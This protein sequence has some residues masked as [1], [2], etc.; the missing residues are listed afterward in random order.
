MARASLPRRQSPRS[1]KPGRRRDDVFRAKGGPALAMLQITDVPRGLRALDA[2]VKEAPVDVLATGTVQCGHYLI[3]FGGQVEATGRSFAKAREIAGET[4]IDSVLL[5]DAEPRIV[6]AFRDAVVRAPNREAG[7]AL[8]VV[9][10]AA[11]PVL[12]ASVDAALKG[13]LVDLVELRVAEGL[14]G[15]ALATFWGLLADVEAAIEIACAV[16]SR[17]VDS[18]A[19]PRAGA[20]FSVI[21]NADDEVQSAV[22]AGTRFFREWRG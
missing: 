10:S 17:Q 7:D 22:A 3:A 11:C 13:A 15:K 18:G 4:T 9:E 5:P 21:P 19:A 1:G 6:L 2:L 16:V 8:G 20:T 12:L 14:G